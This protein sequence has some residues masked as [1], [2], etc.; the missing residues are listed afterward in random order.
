MLDVLYSIAIYVIIPI[1]PID[2]NPCHHSRPSFHLRPE[3]DRRTRHVSKTDTEYYLNTNI[4]G[5]RLRDM[6][7]SCPGCEPVKASSLIQSSSHCFRSL[8][9]L[10]C[11]L[12][13][14]WDVV[15]RFMS[16]RSLLMP[17][18]SQGAHTSTSW[19]ARSST[20]RT[21]PSAGFK[22]LCRSVWP[23]LL[24][25]FCSWRPSTLPPLLQVSPLS[26][27]Y[28]RSDRVESTP[29][30]HSVTRQFSTQTTVACS[31]TLPCQS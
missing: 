6:Y 10:L 2:I 31:G 4:Y 5:N 30:S 8:L 15:R 23:L 7:S 22:E 25:P 28:V 26:T 21:S 24:R 19:T 9:L 3:H 17:T 1:S 16:M 20:K 18:A 29:C 12:S 13:P 11:Q 27:T 14:A